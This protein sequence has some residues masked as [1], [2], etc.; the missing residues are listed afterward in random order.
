[1]ASPWI[2]ALRRTDLGNTETRVFWGSPQRVFR[3]FTD[4]TFA[5][6][7]IPRMSGKVKMQE[8]DLR[9]GGRYSIEVRRR[10]GSTARFFGVYL[11]VDPPRRVVNT[12]EVSTLPG[13]IAI[14]TDEFEA[15]GDS[16]RVTIRW[17]Y[18]SREDLEGMTGPI[19]G[20]DLAALW[21]NVIQISERTR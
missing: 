4:P 10:D 8:L 13:V 21:E 14:E 16:T 20:D 1:M 15:V 7:A 17:Q 6:H 18:A 12:F 2:T 11:E 9:P 19:V 5:A 3:L